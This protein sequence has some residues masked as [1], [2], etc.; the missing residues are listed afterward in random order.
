LKP[1]AE[2]VI[3]V[4]EVSLLSSRLSTQVY[5]AF[6]R[7]TVGKLIFF[8]F[9]KSEVLNPARSRVRNSGALQKGE[10]RVPARLGLV[11]LHPLPEGT[12]PEGDGPAPAPPGPDRGESL[13]T[14]PP[15]RYAC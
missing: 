13:A 12:A 11:P 2:R 7:P 9:L 3:D 8:L 10:R 6:G 5:T 15:G 1:S 14:G 4:S